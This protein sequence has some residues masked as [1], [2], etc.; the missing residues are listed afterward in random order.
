MMLVASQHK[1]H[2]EAR[3]VFTIEGAKLI[4]ESCAICADWGFPLT[5]TDLRMMAKTYLDQAG[6]T[7]SLVEDNLLGC[8]VHIKRTDDGGR[9]PPTNKETM[10]LRLWRPVAD[11][12]YPPASI[13]VVY[14]RYT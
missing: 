10:R 5:I 11:I 3:P 2:E 9:S 7:L 6:K 8:D 4:L 14:E 13:I 12:R 1:L